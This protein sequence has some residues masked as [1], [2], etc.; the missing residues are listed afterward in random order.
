[1]NLDKIKEFIQEVKETIS[2]IAAGCPKPA[3]IP[4]RIKDDRRNKIKRVTY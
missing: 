3:K 1:M 2:W 4:V